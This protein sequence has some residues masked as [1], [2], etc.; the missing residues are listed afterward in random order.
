MSALAVTDHSPVKDRFTTRP[1]LN[2]DQ[3]AMLSRNIESI[4]EF[5]QQFV[6][7]LQQSM[8]PFGFTNDLEHRLLLPE[9]AECCMDYCVPN[10][11]AAISVV[12]TKFATEVRQANL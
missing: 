3:T 11:D 12:C 5:H 4:L 10:I 6:Q 8:G 7:E 1:L 9:E 2:S